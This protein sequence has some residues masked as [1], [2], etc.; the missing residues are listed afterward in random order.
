MNIFNGSI[1]GHQKAMGTLSLRPGLVSLHCLLLWP[2]KKRKIK[3]DEVIKENITYVQKIH[4]SN[5]PGDTDQ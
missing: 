5:F 2:N 4:I 1:M 3:G